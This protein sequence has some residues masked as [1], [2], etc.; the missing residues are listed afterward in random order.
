MVHVQAV[1]AQAAGI[2]PMK[3]GRGGGGKKVAPVFQEIQQGVG[4]VPVDAGLENFDKLLAGAQFG[5]PLSVS[6]VTDSV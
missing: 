4:P 6:Y 2:R 3:F 1:L 5:Y